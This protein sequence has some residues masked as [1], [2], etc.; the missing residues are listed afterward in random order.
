MDFPK[1]KIFMCVVDRSGE[2][3]RLW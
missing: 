1:W 2:T 3:F